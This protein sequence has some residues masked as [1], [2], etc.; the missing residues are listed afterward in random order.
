MKEKRIKNCILISIIILSF[1]IKLVLIFKYK[2]LL[3]LSSDDLKYIN[4]AVVLIKK[5]IF[6]FH[7]YN[8]PTVFVT[9][10]YP[11][12]L[13][14]IFKI[15][16][17][18]MA[19]MQ[20]ARIIQ[21]V[22]S[23]A[24]IVLVYLIA[25]DLFRV[26]IALLSAFI[27]SFYFP[28]IVTVG[29]M[30]T[31]TLFTSLLLT[32]VY[33]SLIF[34]RKPTAL[35]MSFLGIVWAIATLCRPTIALYPIL[36]LFYLLV[37]YKLSLKKVF[38]LGVIM[39]VSFMIV[40]SP[41]WIRNYAEY[42][43]FIPLAASSGNPMLQGTYINYQMTTENTIY[44]KLGENAFETNKIETKTAIYRLKQGF[45]TD[46]WQY[47]RWYTVEKTVLLWNMA[48]YWKEFF[49]VSKYFVLA[50]HY[51]LLLGFIGMVDA[52]IKNYRKFVLLVSI[53][54]YFNFVHCLYM[55]FDR[56]AFPLIPLLSIFTS[57]LI[58]RNRTFAYIKFK[59]Q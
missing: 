30:L 15:F 45:K 58:L 34:S 10:I 51:F 7:N 47:L 23:C 3:T 25:K 11:L 29:Y 38:K 33:L 42:G 27:V 21:A 28:N 54:V 26:E 53:M 19:G 41:W 49:G 2:N 57:F 50:S 22:I 9:P 44:Y 6:T 31:E 48:F 59:K 5:G 39:L 35:K 37:Y 43:Q 56:Y 12:F 36:F 18:G 4:S 13:A 52:L 8:E 20:A 16:G 14:G 40:M 46:F 24:S 32:L 1:L 17:Y 55:S